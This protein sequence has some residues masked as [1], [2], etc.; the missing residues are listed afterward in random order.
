MPKCPVCNSTLTNI[1]LE[2]KHVP[3]NQNVI[4]ETQREALAIPRGELKL[5]VCTQCGFVFNSAFDSSKIAY[6]DNYD[7]S[8]VCSPHFKSYFDDLVNQLLFD[9][10]IQNCRIVEVGCGQGL[11]LRKL[12]E[13]NLGN[14]GYGFDPSYTG[15]LT[16]LDGQL[17]FIKSYYTSESADVAADVVV[18]RHVIE[19]VP[20]PL[21]LLLNIKQALHNSVNTRIFSETPCVEWILKHQVIWDFFYEH[22]SY[23]T[24]ESLTTAF[25]KA[26]FKVD[27]VHHVF[28]GQYLWLEASVSNKPLEITQNV[29]QIPDLANK[30]TASEN[31]LKQNLLEKISQLLTKGKVAIWGA[32]A[33]GVTLANLIDPQQ[34]LISCVVDLNPNK[35]EKFIPGSGHPIINYQNLPD[36][37]IVSVILMNPNYYAENLA[38]LHESGININLVNLME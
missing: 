30:F 16:D 17:N 7:N 22:C 24:K 3:V 13:A 20:E 37:N 35:Q 25:E 18:C 19:H 8:Q 33:K 11:F 1:F 32:G 21:Q 23:F 5:A 31:Q 9:K 38:L 10:G 15:P 14:S 4:I 34:E 27:A 12:V 26:G 2:R 29:G 28:G 36:Y 6:N